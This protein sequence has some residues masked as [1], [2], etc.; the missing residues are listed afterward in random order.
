MIFTCV[1]ILQN[2]NYTIHANDE[3][4][5]T[6]LCIYYTK[7]KWVRK[8]NKLTFLHRFYIFFIQTNILNKIY[9]KFIFYFMNFC[10][11]IRF[12]TL[13]LAQVLMFSYLIF[14][15]DVLNPDATVYIKCCKKIRNVTD[16]EMIENKTEKFLHKTPL[17]A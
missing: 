6:H 17:N 16:I 2:S 14:L 4:V 11:K 10:Q 9:M 7:R 5:D 12:G 8:T 1:N 15:F 3:S 13:L